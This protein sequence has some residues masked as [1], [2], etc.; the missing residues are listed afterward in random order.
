MP[1]REA[2]AIE[3]ESVSVASTLS[4]SEA[5]RANAQ[6]IAA[7]PEMLEALIAARTYARESG[8]SY[9][10]AIDQA[11]AQAKGDV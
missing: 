1:T 11:I 7:A 5:S 4:D 6:L 9:P 8:L 10:E 2:F 3:N